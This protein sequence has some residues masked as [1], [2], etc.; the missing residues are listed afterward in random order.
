M[1]RDTRS[2][3]QPPVT[4]PRDRL[5]DPP[6]AADILGPR[7]RDARP[8]ATPSPHPGNTSALRREILYALRTA[9]AASPDQIADTIGAS[10]T[11]VLQQ[12]H[13]LELAGL[14]TKTVLRHGVG[15]PRHV[16]DLTVTAQALVP[17]NYGALAEAVLDAVRRIGGEELVQQVFEARRAALKERLQK[18][19]AER[20]P[21]SAS[22]WERVSE[23][24]S[25]QDENGYLGRATREPDGTIRLCEHNCAIS[26]VSGSNQEACD[27][28]LALFSEVLGARLVRES[29]I[30]SGARSCTYRV[31]PGGKS[32]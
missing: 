25:F 9:G 13:T 5:A 19:L 6:A 23:V 12:L 30:V 10:R 21:R 14:V 28:E 16:Y 15:R 22:L 31:E 8:L 3:G 11:G 2:A 17:A 18:R 29:H 27:A 24:A 4:T 1:D 20:L 26:A 7:L 32:D